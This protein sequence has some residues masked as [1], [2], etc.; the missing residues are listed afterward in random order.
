MYR[1]IRQ[2][3]SPLSGMAHADDVAEKVLEGQRHQHKKT[4]RSLDNMVAILAVLTLAAAFVPGLGLFVMFAA[5]LPCFIIVVLG[6]ILLTKGAVFRGV[7]AMLLG[8]VGLPVAL[9]V[10]PMMPMFRSSGGVD[11]PKAFVAKFEQTLKE[12]IEKASKMQGGLPAGAFP[13]MGSGSE[14]GAGLGG[15]S[16]GSSVEI[17]DIDIMEVHLERTMGPQGR[18]AFLTRVDW[19]NNSTHPVSNLK[20]T[21][22]LYDDYGVIQGSEVS[23]YSGEPVPPGQTYFSPKGKGHLYVPVPGLLGSPKRSEVELIAAE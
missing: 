6:V 21:V 20:A 3:G 14:A 18:P 22:K 11:D 4:I 16:V 8:F 1:R 5:I 17:K 23:L 19:K 10:I 15:G 12:L 9:A 2:D 13:G 7:F